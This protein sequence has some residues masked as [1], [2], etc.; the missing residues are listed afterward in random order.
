MTEFKKNKKYVLKK[1]PSAKTILK[2][3]G[4]Y[5]VVDSCGKAVSSPEELLMPQ[6]TSVQEAW[7]QARYGLWFSGMIQK[8][9]NAF[10]EE[11]MWKSL[12]D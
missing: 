9:N 2:S 5:I 1:V 6:A 10:N 11:K 12:K 7:R 3:N 8:S 4:T